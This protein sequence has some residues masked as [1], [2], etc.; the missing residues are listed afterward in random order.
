LFL[1]FVRQ[2]VVFVFPVAVGRRLPFGAH[3]SSLF[4]A[5]QRWIERTVLHLQK[6]VGG[7][8]NVL[9]DLMAMS[10]SIEKRSQDEHVK[11]ALEK[12][13]ALL[14][15]LLRHKRQSTLNL[16]DGRCS[17]IACQGCPETMDSQRMI[18]V[19]YPANQR[20]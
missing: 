7:P 2:S 8:L 19:R 10:R 1:A 17:T 15:C 12:A 20:K 3:P 11:S 6:I 13:R 18:S 16:A 14:L 4:Q 5:M 9:A